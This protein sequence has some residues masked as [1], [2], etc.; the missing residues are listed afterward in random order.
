MQNGI[1]QLIEMIFKL[2]MQF[3]A[4][5]QGLTQD[6]LGR[7]GTGLTPQLLNRM[8]MSRESRRA[9][10][11]LMGKQKSFNLKPI[12]SRKGDLLCEADFK[13]WSK[14]IDKKLN[15]SIKELGLDGSAARIFKDRV[16]GI[17]RQ[18]DQIARK[19]TDPVERNMEM[20]RLIDR[21]IKEAKGLSVGLPESEAIRVTETRYMGERKAGAGLLGGGMVEKQ[22]MFNGEGMS[23]SV[24]VWMPAVAEE[25]L[26]RNS[27]DMLMEHKSQLESGTALSKSADEARQIFNLREGLR[28]GTLSAEDVVRQSMKMCDQGNGELIAQFGLENEYKDYQMAKLLGNANKMSSLIGQMT[29]KVE[30]FIK[31]VHGQGTELLGTQIDVA[32]GQGMSFGMHI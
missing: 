9:Y 10:D 1:I 22:A 21:Q 11:D 17:A 24:P 27:K 26:S 12:A 6:G 20:S 4:N 3:N 5:Q 14:E 31:Q 15:E 16:G 23:A 29:H 7:T 19:Y 30:D 8:M 2:A 28:R 25:R 18:M 13:G 32:Q